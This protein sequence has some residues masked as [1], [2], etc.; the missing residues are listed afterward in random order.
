MAGLEVSLCILILHYDVLDGK[1][2]E[3]VGDNLTFFVFST[4]IKS[5][6]P[7]VTPWPSSLFQSGPFLF[8]SVP[9]PMHS[10]GLGKRYSHTWSLN[11]K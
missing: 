1:D 9:G 4:S 6:Q 2:A 7:F 8:T 5:C 11:Q 3:R 10:T